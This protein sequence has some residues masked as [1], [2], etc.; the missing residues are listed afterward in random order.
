MQKPC[1]YFN[2]GIVA[3]QQN[4]FQER[5]LFCPYGNRCHYAHMVPNSTHRFWFSTQRIRE[6][7]LERSE[8]RQQELQSGNINTFDTESDS[9]PD[10]DD[11]AAAN[12]R[13]RQAFTEIDAISDQL[14]SQE[15]LQRYQQA[16]MQEISRR[17]IAQREASLRAGARGLVHPYNNI[18][19]W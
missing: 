8:L 6:M 10:I 2:E 13:L 12:E 4:E 7:I 15:L 17:A 1:Q 18:P 11:I 9:N 14:T 16:Q 3:W 5:F 19:L